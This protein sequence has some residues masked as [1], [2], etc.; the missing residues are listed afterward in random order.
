VISWVLNGLDVVAQNAA[1]RT[2]DD[3]LAHNTFWLTARSGQ[4]LGD[5]AAELLAERVREHV[6]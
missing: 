1:L 2:S 3:G 5:E 4:K 6:M